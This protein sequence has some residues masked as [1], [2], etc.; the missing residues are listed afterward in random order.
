MKLQNFDIHYS[1]F[2]IRYSLFQNPIFAAFESLNRQV[3]HGNAVRQ[4]AVTD[5][6]ETNT[7]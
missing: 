4:F 2:D 5:I 7:F 1:L 3:Y 6:G